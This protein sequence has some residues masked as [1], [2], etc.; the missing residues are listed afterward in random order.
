LSGT[1][2]NSRHVHHGAYV[3][4]GGML[5]VCLAEEK[6]VIMAS[7]EMINKNMEGGNNI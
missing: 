7:H 3:L 4:F 6:I 2:I 5:K 1:V